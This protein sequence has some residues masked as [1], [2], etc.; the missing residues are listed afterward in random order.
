MKPW[1]LR[2]H[3]TEITQLRLQGW[4][5]Q[6]IADKFGA[7][8]EG[9]RYALARHLIKLQDGQANSVQPARRPA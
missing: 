1:G 8:K 5:L 4:T 9:V 3:D 7:T 6:E 2:E